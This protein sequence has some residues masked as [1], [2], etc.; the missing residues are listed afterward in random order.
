[1]KINKNQYNIDKESKNALKSYKN[2]QININIKYHKIAI[3]LSI[4]I[5]LGLICFI[6]FYK[7]KI[8]YY[9]LNIF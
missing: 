3:A 2:N 4:F 7:T 9:N 5:N 8:K 1:M 6:F